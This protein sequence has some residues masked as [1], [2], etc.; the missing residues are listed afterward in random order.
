MLVIHVDADVAGKNYRDD[1]RVSDAPNDLPCERPCPPASATTDAL[2]QV[3]LGW[4]GE[5]ATPP[6]T[7]LCTPSKAIET[8]V[9]VA[10]YPLN[11]FSAGNDV[12]CRTNP[13]TQL[14]SQPSA[15]RLIRGGKKDRQKYREF[16]PAVAHA[17]PHVRLCCTEAERFSTEFL[18]AVP[19][20]LPIPAV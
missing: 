9:L 13:E 16:A 12:E 5:T 20:R 17:W 15:Q 6:K 8:W 7:I 1:Q 14:Q 18:A 10:L 19:Q 11:Q 4:M 2:R 3:V